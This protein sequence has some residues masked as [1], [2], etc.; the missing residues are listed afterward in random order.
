MQ[1]FTD[2][3]HMV[4]IFFHNPW[5]TDCQ[6]SILFSFPLRKMPIY[7]KFECCYQE[8]TW[9]VDISYFDGPI[10]KG[11]ISLTGSFTNQ[12]T[13]Q[14][15]NNPNGLTAV[16]TLQTDIS[17][18]PIIWE[19]FWSSDQSTWELHL[20]LFSLDKHVHINHCF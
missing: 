11:S 20:N 12:A 18:V 8:I 10:C 19:E 3:Y 15:N 4:V 7:W 14:K 17:I 9:N 16:D 2:S 5:Q 1:V 6:I 13:N